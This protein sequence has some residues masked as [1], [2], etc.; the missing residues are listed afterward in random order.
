MSPTSKGKLRTILICDKNSQ[1][2]ETRNENRSL[3]QNYGYR[4]ISV[5]MPS[6]GL[7][8]ATPDPEIYRIAAENSWQIIT[9]DDDFMDVVRT[10]LATDPN[11]MTDVFWYW[12]EVKSAKEIFI[13]VDKAS[14]GE[15]DSEPGLPRFYD[16]YRWFPRQ[17]QEYLVHVRSLLISKAKKR[18]LTPEQ[19]GKVAYY[20]SAGSCRLCGRFCIQLYDGYGDKCRKKVLGD[21]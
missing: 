14:R 9:H 10:A 6:S 15:L 3:A 18:P 19:L 5:G 12:D 4:I 21:S 7:D 1:W 11:K 8:R 2:I 16:T 20:E 17:Y 13:L